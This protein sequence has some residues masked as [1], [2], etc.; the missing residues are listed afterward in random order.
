MLNT[1]EH[2]RRALLLL[3]V[4]REMASF[5]AITGEEEAATALIK[6]MQLRKYP[7]AKRFNARDHQ[8]KVAV[9]AC[10]LAIANQLHPAL[11]EFQLT[12]NFETKRIDIKIPLSNFGVNGGDNYC[13]QPVEPL[14]FLHSQP[15]ADEN[16]LFEGA[17]QS[18]AKRSNFEGIKRMVAELSNS[19]NRLLYA[20][21]AAVP[22]SVATA[23]MIENRRSSAMI[24]LVIGIM[25]LQSRK[26]LGLVLQASQ[27]FLR[28]IDKLPP[29]AKLSE[30]A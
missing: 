24:L 15:G 4:D 20:S 10:V 5:R 19:R 30:S 26:H 25:I 23:E 13:V 18:F 29:E 28:I 9:R 22:K 3:E 1:F 6:A 8:H 27:A 11:R 7:D 17:L 16:S 12:F 14:D 21:D 2:F